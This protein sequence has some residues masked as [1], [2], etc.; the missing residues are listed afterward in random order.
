[1]TSFGQGNLKVEEYIREF[2]QLQLN[3]RLNKDEELTIAGLIKR[4][5]P[6]IAHKGELQLYLTFDDMYK[7][8]T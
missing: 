8:T 2:G 6:S 5:S 7:C 3:I 1:M 4:S